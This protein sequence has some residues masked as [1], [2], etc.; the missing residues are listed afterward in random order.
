MTDESATLYYRR[1]NKYVV[2]I[3]RKE[4]SPSCVSHL[5]REP[6]SDQV[7]DPTNEFASD[8]H[9]N[10]APLLDKVENILLMILEEVKAI[11]LNT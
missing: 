5:N 3:I 6:L 2:E 10:R 4:E 7:A 9:L 1:L 11:Q 8:S